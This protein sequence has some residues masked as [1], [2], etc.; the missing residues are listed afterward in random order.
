MLA[1][2]HEGNIF[3]LSFEYIFVS[4]KCVSPG[5]LPMCISYTH[6]SPL[7]YWEDS[8]GLIK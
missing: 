2:T 7:C 4:K 6:W 5:A 1:V 3:E 8:L